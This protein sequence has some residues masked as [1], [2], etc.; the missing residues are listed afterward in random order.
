MN[1][2]EIRSKKARKLSGL[3]QSQAAKAIGISREAISQWEN[4]G[5]KS[6]KSSLL[7]NVASV[8]GVSASWLATGKGEMLN[9]REESP[10]Y[11]SSKQVSISLYENKKILN[12]KNEFEITQFV[13]SQS[14]VSQNLKHSTAIEDIRIITAQGNSMSPTIEHGSLVFIDTSVNTFTGDHL[15]VLKVETTD[16]VIKRVQILSNGNYLLINDNQ[17]NQ[18]EKVE[19]INIIGRVIGTMNYNNL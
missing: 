12:R 1:S 16:L 14:W 8:Y 15:Y 6:I 10:D 5:T 3:N 13:A 9:V 7:H 19:S 11:I 18:S 2:L 17:S 4:G